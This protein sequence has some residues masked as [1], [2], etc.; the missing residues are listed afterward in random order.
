MVRIKNR[1]LLVDILYPGLDNATTN[2]KLPDVVLFNQ[3]TTG[4]LTAQA[5]LRG[6]KAEVAN[7]FGD[8]GSGAIADSLA[9]KSSL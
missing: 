6:L 5:L 8:Y 7:I 4:G 3:P 9:S 1:Y 2:S